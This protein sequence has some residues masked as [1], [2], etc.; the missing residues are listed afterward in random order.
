MTYD[1]LTKLLAKIAI[2]ATSIEL[3]SNFEVLFVRRSTS[4]MFV[5]FNRTRREHGKIH[6]I[7]KG[8]L[9][10]RPAEVNGVSSSIGKQTKL[11]SSISILSLT[12]PGQDSDMNAFKL[13]TVQL[14]A[15]LCYL[16][17]ARG[18]LD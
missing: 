12:I 17:P 18:R 10:S 15:V 1:Q 9:T 16:H 7:G 6:C 11:I 4:D 2:D 8:A 13:T 5:Q 3:V 14:D